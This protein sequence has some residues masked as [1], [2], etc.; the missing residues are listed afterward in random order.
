MV[1]FRDRKYIG[2]F[3]GL[4]EGKQNLGSHLNDRHGRAS[5]I[6]YHFKHTMENFVAI[7]MDQ[8]ALY[9]FIWKVF[10]DK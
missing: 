6:N 3:Q 9:I 1:K 10:Q 4:E 2:G 7:K 5:Q 8:D